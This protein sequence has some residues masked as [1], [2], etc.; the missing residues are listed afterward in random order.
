MSG[1]IDHH[2]E[3]APVNATKAGC[4][5]PA[6]FDG[7]AIGDLATGKHSEKLTGVITAD[8]DCSFGVDAQTIRMAIP[9]KVGEYPVLAESAVGQI[10][11]GENPR[12]VHLVDH[13]G[14]PV[15]QHPETI[16][17]RKIRRDD[18]HVTFVL[19]E[20]DST[21]HRSSVALVEIDE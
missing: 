9:L 14:Q 13:E 15:G 6:L 2:V 7:N 19:Y 3:G 10:R 8:P 16:R 5:C 17:Y 21:A 18:A 11:I 1:V 20:S 4:D 12:A